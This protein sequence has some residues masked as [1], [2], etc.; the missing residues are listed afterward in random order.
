MKLLSKQSSS[1]AYSMLL[2]HKQLAASESPILYLISN[3][4]SSQ[5][6]KLD[7]QAIKLDEAS[8]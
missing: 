1:A 5:A 2:Q 6:V 4:P 8:N 3:Y 7:G